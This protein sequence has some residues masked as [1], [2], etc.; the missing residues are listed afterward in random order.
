MRRGHQ[1]DLLPLRVA[2]L[3]PL[4]VRP[5]GRRAAL[6]LPG[7]LGDQLA[8]DRRAVARNVP[9]PI[10]VTGLVLTR[11]QPE[12]AADRLG[13]AKAVRIVH[14]GDHRFGRADAYPRDAAQLS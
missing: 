2:P 13:M 5:D 12:I 6:R 10:P 9:E 4:E 7:R 3:D 14:E 11:N 1:R 8:D